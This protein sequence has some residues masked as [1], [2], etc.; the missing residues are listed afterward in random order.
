[1]NFEQ[2]LK[3][4]LEYCDYSGE[5]RKFIEEEIKNAHFMYPDLQLSRGW[6]SNE[7]HCIGLIG[8]LNIEKGSRTVKVP[9]G[10]CYP[11]GYPDQPPLCTI[12]T[13][14]NEVILQNSNKIDK[15][16]N[17]VVDAVRNWNRSRDSIEVI[18]QCTSFISE[19][20][21]WYSLEEIFM[22]EMW[23][24]KR[25][26][27]EMNNDKRALTKSIK[28]IQEKNKNL[29][30]MTQFG[31]LQ[32][33]NERCVGLRTCMSSLN[34]N[35]T[36]DSIFEYKN[37]VAKQLL[38]VSAEL[39]AIDEVAIKL[40]ESLKARVLSTND[41]FVSLK[42]IYTKRFLLLRLKDKISALI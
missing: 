3:T 27:D 5:Q 6:G 35:L 39:E 22:S 29:A 23:R 16:G 9:F 25:Q 24:I 19:Q 11:V 20:M 4:M 2:E 13:K 31:V 10:V 18:L 14:S 40:E 32:N 8:H 21:P 7:D 15:R 1:M 38:E 28:D 34:T 41:Y 12:I 30:Y 26:I 33:M 37:P 42:S 17:L 36:L